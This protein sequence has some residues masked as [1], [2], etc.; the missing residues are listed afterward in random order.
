MKLTSRNGEHNGIYTVIDHH[1][2][3]GG[4]DVLIQCDI[5]GQKWT[6]SLKSLHGYDLEHCCCD[7]FAA[8]EMKR[9]S[10]LCKEA[11]KGAD[12]CRCKGYFNQYLKEYLAKHP[13][14]KYDDFDKIWEA[15]GKKPEDTEFC[16]WYLTRKYRG[17]RCPDFTADNMEWHPITTGKAII[18]AENCLPGSTHRSHVQHAKKANKSRDVKE[19]ER[20][21]KLLKKKT[22]DAE[23]VYRSFVGRKF[24]SFEV[25]D[26][27]MSK[28]KNSTQYFFVLKCNKCGKVVMRIASNVLKDCRPCKC[29]ST[30]GRSM[31]NSSTHC[32]SWLMKKKYC[33]FKNEQFSGIN[34]DFQIFLQAHLS[35]YTLSCLTPRYIELV[36]ESTLMCHIK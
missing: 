31:K 13:D 27:H 11:Q 35:E 22:K 15:V 28:T 7:R 20:S 32:R 6:R 24:K 21:C 3:S 34:P 17:R 25:I 16:K 2:T 1:K 10:R 23:D 14:V 18:L 19:F 4:Q 12:Y 26:M 33:F 9:N 5:C 29:R 8:N 36:A 30:A